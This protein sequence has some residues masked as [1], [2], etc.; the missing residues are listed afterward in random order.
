MA[1][2]LTG[3]TVEARNSFGKQVTEG[4][5]VF[6]VKITGKFFRVSFFHALSFPSSLPSLG[7]TSDISPKIS[8]GGDGTYI[9]EYLP[10][11]QGNHFI[12]VMYKGQQIKDSPFQ[13]NVASKY[14][15]AS[16]LCYCFFFFFF[17]FSYAFS[18]PPL[19][20]SSSSPSCSPSFL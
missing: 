17:S 5:T 4:G 15:E 20:P 16:F 1:D 13:V 6:H 3:F 18:Y 11:E 19:L 9:I 7:P 10:T 12:Q 8:D 2:A 14:R